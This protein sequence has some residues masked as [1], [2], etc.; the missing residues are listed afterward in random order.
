MRVRALAG[1]WR[2]LPTRTIR[3]RLAAIY[4]TLFILCAAGLLG[5]TYGVVSQQYTAA[6][7]ISSGVQAGG[8]TVRAGPANG[9]SGKAQRSSGIGGGTVHDDGPESHR[10]RGALAARA[11]DRR[12]GPGERRARHAAALVGDRPRESWR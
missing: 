1:R 9:S 6:Y 8:I 2:S 4:T 3:T 12:R 5:I 11:G 10:V 7:F